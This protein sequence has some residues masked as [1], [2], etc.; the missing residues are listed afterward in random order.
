MTSFARRISLPLLFLCILLQV[1]PSSALAKTPNYA[2][3]LE[4]YARKA[5]FDTYIDEVQAEYRTLVSTD[6]PQILPALYAGLASTKP[7]MRKAA[8]FL[9]GQRGEAKAI[10][11]L[12][13]LLQDTDAGVREQAVSAL[14]NIYGFDDV[15]PLAALLSDPAVNVRLA[16]VTDLYRFGAASFEPLVTA[17]Q[18][19]DAG[20]RRAAVSSLQ[21]LNDPRSVAPLTL[22]LS[23]RDSTVCIA[24]VDALGKLK[25][26]D[27]LLKAAPAADTKVRIRLLRVL[28]GV[29]D[30]RA[31]DVLYAA[32]HDADATVRAEAVRRLPWKTPGALELLYAALQDTEPAVRQGALR[33]V[34]D[35]L[36]DTEAVEHL[37]PLLDDADEKIR[38]SVARRLANYRQPNIITSL[39]ARLARPDSPFEVQI[40]LARQGD[41][42]VIPTL[43][44]LLAGWHSDE[45]GTEEGYRA[46]EASYLLVLLQESAPVA[47]PLLA[48][49]M[50][51]DARLRAGAARTLGQID[52]P[53]VVPALIA[54][55][56]DRDRG[57]RLAVLRALA[58]QLDARSYDAVL[59]LLNEKDADIR[60][61]AAGALLFCQDARMLPALKRMLASRNEHERM[62]AVTTLATLADPQALPLLTKALRDRNAGVRGTA[63]TACLPRAYDSRTLEAIVKAAVGT[64]MLSSY[65]LQDLPEGY[66]PEVARPVLLRALGAKDP[67]QRIMAAQALAQFPA[68][69]V[70]AALMKAMT[71]PEDAVRIAAGLAL[72]Q[73]ADPAMFPSLVKLLD[74]PLYAANTRGRDTVIELLGY[75]GTTGADM[76]LKLLA[77]TK[78]DD[79]RYT[80]YAALQSTGDP[81]AVDVLIGGLGS[82]SGSD[83]AS[84][85]TGLGALG[86]ARAIPPLIQALGRK[87]LVLSYPVKALGALKAREAVEPLCRMLQNGYWSKEIIEALGEIGDPRAVE[88]LLPLLD[89]SQDT[90]IAGRSETI[91]AAIKALTQLGDPR[92]AA[93]VLSL[94]KRCLYDDHADGVC[95]TAV[96]ALSVLPDAAAR[97]EAKAFL[98]A[99]HT[100]RAAEVLRRFEPGSDADELLT[101]VR[102]IPGEFWIPVEPGKA[103]GRIRDGKEQERLTGLTHSDSWR[104]R[105]AAAYALGENKAPWAL[106]ALTALLADPQL[107]VR[108]AALDALS[109]ARGETVE[110]T[111]AWAK[112][113]LSAEIRKAAEELQRFN[114]T[115]MSI[116]E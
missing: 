47:E 70:T 30:P 81:R 109:N 21:V 11:Q 14:E 105:C 52:D 1:L 88:A 92:A 7:G 56:K 68:P 87:D 112:Q 75:T 54:A 6:D 57:V 15:K 82:E 31:Y 86:D 108:G 67:A 103:L 90:L 10:P 116:G 98:Q 8:V 115:F 12:L 41:P 59:P 27:P 16:V 85:A 84:A 2:R 102:M 48:A 35:R 29:A 63:V 19:S 73:I 37:L 55:L 69:E 28:A 99:E 13:D 62:A 80:F 38:V 43:I 26:L 83:A 20:V 110:V 106:E 23:D 24:A 91:M 33:R 61:A 60:C 4:T 66:R 40:A 111:L 101:E 100:P 78:P 49:L 71:D 64:D 44:P 113:H 93:P 3:L 58:L 22:L 76:L 50:S 79:N 18:D 65:L 9:L 94:L 74:H 107:L 36:L 25:A 39:E 32:S 72:G 114:P 51:E 95:R 53:R 42:R 45:N 104:A 17:L 77:E 96:Q 46:N 97:N 5:A 34:S 89:A